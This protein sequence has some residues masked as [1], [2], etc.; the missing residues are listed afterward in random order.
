MTYSRGRQNSR[1]RHRRRLFYMADFETTTDPNDCRVWGY[2]LEN[3]EE[4]GVE[5]GPTLDEFMHRIEA[6]NAVIFFHNLKFDGHFIIDWL[7]KHDFW[8]VENSRT[9]APGCF[10]ALI[11]DTGK[12]YSINIHFENGVQVELRDSLKKLP[13]SVARIATAFKLGEV[14]GDIDYEAHRPPNHTITPEEADYIRRD[15]NIVSQALKQTIDAGATKLTVG[16]DALAE[17]KKVLGEDRFKK[18]FPVF[19]HNMDAE[20]RRAYRGGFT[21]ADPRFARTLQGA[22]QVYDVNSLYPSVMYQQPMPY[23]EPEF[24]EGFV[25]PTATRPLT[26]FSVTFTARL[27]PNHI[28]C[29][30]IK[31]TSMFVPT[32]YLS[33]IDEP[34]TLMV[35]DVDWKLYQDHYDIDVL[36]YGGGWRFHAVTGVFKEYIDKWSQIKET[37]TGAMRELAKLMLNSL[38]GKFA[39]NPNV[40]GKHPYLGDDGSVKYRTGQEETRNPVYTAVGVYITSY[41]RDLTVRAAQQHYDVF[42]Y[43][44]TDSLHLLTTDTP[45]GLDIHPTRMGAWSHEYDF[46]NAKFLR[47]KAYLEKHADGSYTNRIAGLPEHVSKKLTFEQVKPGV[48]LHGKLVPKSV[49]GGIVLVDTPYE[50]K[51]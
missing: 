31:G 14:K 41:A 17:F 22:G 24:V 44:D 4:P 39:S 32:E 28:P 38:Y 29:I 45:T 37:S 20:I 23:G 7:L 15:V 43:A 3:I 16:S 13:F 35:T 50:L 8:Y 30:Q 51:Y 40:T 9:I 34:T 48:I 25:E 11:S 19:N 33:V 49:P 1:R 46:A 18:L 12:F 10:K 2:G 47:S 26:I 6:D 5:I 21:Y 42:A 27:K 36:E